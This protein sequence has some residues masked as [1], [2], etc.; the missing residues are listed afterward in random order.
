[1]LLWIPV[2]FSSISC[3]ICSICFG[4]G[5]AFDEAEAF[6]VF[7]M[8]LEENFG[9]CELPYFWYSCS[10]CITSLLQYFKSH[11]INLE[12]R[13]HTSSNAQDQY[14]QAITLIADKFY[15]SLHG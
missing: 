2:Y 6:F 15:A 14:L 5:G 11:L 13:S 7:V 9:C 4:I 10:S 12:G 8:M 1:M 3:A